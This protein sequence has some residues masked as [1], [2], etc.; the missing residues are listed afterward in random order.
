MDKL[1]LFHGNTES[2]IDEIVANKEI[3]DKFMSKGDTHYLGD[4]FY[5]YDDPI[6]AQVWAKMKVSRKY[7]YRDQNWAVLK[8]EIEYDDA[9]MFMDLDKRAEQNFYFREMLRLHNKILEKR[10]GSIIE[11]NDAYLCNYLTKKLGL[12]IITKTFVYQ[13]LYNKFPTLFS[14]T[15]ASPYSI[16]RH[17]RTEKQYVIKSDKF[18]IS[19]EKIDSGKIKKRG[20]A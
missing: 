8:C 5:F 3:P 1:I 16:T 11:Y 4:G 15:K 13:D 19:Y 10:L 18:I 20:G 9:S 2:A 6:Q 17:F 14:N 12:E 7:K